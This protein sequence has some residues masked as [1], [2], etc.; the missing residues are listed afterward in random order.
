ML[1]STDVESVSVPVRDDKYIDEYAK[2]F[3]NMSREE[4][5]EF[6]EILDSAC[7]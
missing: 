2:L 6:M 1:Y 5:I 3:P 7:F 4:V